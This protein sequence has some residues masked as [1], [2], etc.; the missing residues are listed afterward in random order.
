M[1]SRTEYIQGYENY[2]QRNKL[3]Y[4][5]T[6]SKTNIN[7]NNNNSNRRNEKFNS[8]VWRQINLMHTPQK[9]K[10]KKKK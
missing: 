10:K 1:T 5:K 9:S 4:P 7:N 8:R 2:P 6:E 3:L